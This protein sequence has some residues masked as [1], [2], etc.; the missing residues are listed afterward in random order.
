MKDIHKRMLL[1]LIGCMGARTG[2]AYAAY[3]AGRRPSPTWL[4][5]MAV[6][7]LAVSLGFFVIY[8]A[9]WRETGPEVFGERIWWNDLRPVHAALYLAFAAMAV[10]GSPNAWVPLGLDVALGLGAFILHHA[11]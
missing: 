9:G 7:A 6:P 1:F 4:R 2:L 3:A 10:R 5:V 11:T 8:L